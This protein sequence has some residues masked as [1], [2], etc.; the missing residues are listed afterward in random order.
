[1]AA[2]HASPPGEIRLLLGGDVMTGRAIDLV[3]RWPQPAAG[4]GLRP[5]DARRRLRAAEALHGPIPL[6]NEPD[7]VWGDA[8]AEMDRLRVPLRIVNLATAV[9]SANTAW[10]GKAEP[11]RMSPRH[12]DC[13][14]A[15]RIS[16]CALANDRVLDWDYP[17]LK[18]T[19]RLLAQAGIVGVGAGID[20][21]SAQT[22]A[23]LDTGSGSRVLVFSWATPDA[24]VPAG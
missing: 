17:G 10:L 11:V 12:A 6:R 22:P 20:L 21:A 4:S 16:A 15:A 3:M 5:R 13:L 8:L 18:E 19:L 2:P 24:G 9:T 14:A 23:V 7:Y 1:M